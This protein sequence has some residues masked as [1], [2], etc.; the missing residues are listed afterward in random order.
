MTTLTVL[1]HYAMQIE[2]LEDSITTGKVLT[3][4]EIKYLEEL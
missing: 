1:Y 2:R 4:E 3:P